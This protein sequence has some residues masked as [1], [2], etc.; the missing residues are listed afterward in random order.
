MSKVNF[1]E[2]FGSLSL[3]DIP[4]YDATPHQ[5]IIAL[6]PPTV[7]EL[8]DA[9]SYC[10]QQYSGTRIPFQLTVDSGAFE[11]GEALELE[12]IIQAGF[13]PDSNKERVKIPLM[14][15]HA[16]ARVEQNITVSG[17]STSATQPPASTVFTEIHGDIS[18]PQIDDLEGHQL[19]ISLNEVG[20]NDDLQP[21]FNRISETS[22]QVRTL[23]A[24]F[25][26]RYDNNVL[27]SGRSYDLLFILRAPSGK[28]VAGRNLRNI[29]LAELT[30]AQQVTLGRP[31]G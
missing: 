30:E 2:L 10:I 17:S 12:A 3:V 28:F 31:R 27:T 9:R 13:G 6:T 11:A 29:D 23:K 21:F 1:I 20:L 19:I 25:S 22:Y 15:N 5:V 24:P 14:L 8:R 7:T 16:T 18:I 26:L 4:H